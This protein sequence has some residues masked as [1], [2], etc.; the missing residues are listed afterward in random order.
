[1]LLG[2]CE[3]L[4]ET[5]PELTTDP[6]V[7]E[8]HAHHL[9]S[10]IDAAPVR[11]HRKDSTAVNGVTSIAAAT[12]T[13][14]ISDLRS[15]FSYA[16]KILKASH[17]DASQAFADR[18]DELKSNKSRQKSS[19]KPF[20]NKQLEQIFE[21]KT[22]LA[23]NRAADYFW[24]PLLGI[25]LGCRLGEIVTW[26]LASIQRDDANGIWSLQVEDERAKNEHSVRRLP[27]PDRLI[28][29]GFIEYVEHLRK[30]GATQLFV[31]TVSRPH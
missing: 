14:K 11:R 9:A 20:N 4:G 30:M 26:E 12:A 18:V 16:H 19:Y 6:W 2:L 27:L 15:F 10:F 25:H 29:L 5:F 31:S 23:F 17:E 8:I 22:Y 24:A 7:H 1:M 28:E 13:K 3:H 21:P